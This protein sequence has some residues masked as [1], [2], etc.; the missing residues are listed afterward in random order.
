MDWPY[1]LKEKKKMVK[2]DSNSTISI[3]KITIAQTQGEWSTNS[4]TLF[5]SKYKNG[6]KS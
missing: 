2:A 3:V 6:R 1:I 5:N 4:V